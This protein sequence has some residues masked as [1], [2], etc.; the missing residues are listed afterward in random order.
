LAELRTARRLH[1]V[2]D[3]QD[4]LQAVEFNFPRYGPAAL[5]LNCCNFCNSSRRV[6]LAG[7]EDVLDVLGNDRLIALK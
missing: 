2:A 7:L 1:A 5:G 6:D 3:G 4:H